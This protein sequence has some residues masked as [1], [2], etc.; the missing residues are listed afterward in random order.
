MAGLQTDEIE[1]QTTSQHNN[2]ISFDH[3]KT[4]PT[5]KNQN[6]FSNI[7]R[8]NRKELN[9]ILR[10][11]GFRVASGDWR[12]Y[13]IDMLKGRAVF[14]VFRRTS[15]V[16]LYMIEKNPKLERRQ[17]AYSVINASGHVL[18]RGHELVQVLK[19]FDRKP[20]LVSI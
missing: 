14:S 15:E 8:F 11:Y 16:P 10:V 18:K 3:V 20:K 1:D 4:T 7:V 12:D 6:D 5:Q 17:G 2:L 19:F 13:A 9:L